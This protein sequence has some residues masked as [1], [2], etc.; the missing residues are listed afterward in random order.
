MDKCSKIKK[1]ASFC[2][3]VLTKDI[4]SGKLGTTSKKPQTVE[5]EIKSADALTE[6]SGRWKPDRD[7]G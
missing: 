3:K 2:T 1:S 7:A 6:S 5:T 4:R